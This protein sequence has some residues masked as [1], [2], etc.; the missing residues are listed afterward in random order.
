MKP[1]LLLIALSL[2]LPAAPALA[3]PKACNA[4]AKD[5]VLSIALPAAPAAAV[6]G[7]DGCTLYVSLPGEIA[8]LSRAD[9]AATLLHRSPVKGL[10]GALAVSPDGRMLAAATGEGATVLDTAR[11][12]SGQGDP[13]IGA[14]QEKGGGINVV[15]GKDSRSLFVAGG[16]SE[17]VGVFE[18]GKLA[19][20]GEIAVGRWSSGLALSPDGARLYATVQ[21]VDGKAADCSPPDGQASWMSPGELA[22]IDVAKAAVVGRAAAGCNPARVALSPSGDTAYVTARGD[23]A[24]TAIAA[25]TMSVQAPIKGVG[26]PVA[27][28]AGPGALFVTGSDASVAVLKPGAAPGSIAVKGG[29]VSAA[30]TADGRTLLVVETD[31]NTLDIVDLARAAK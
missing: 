24:V 15:F 25:K 4:P 19:R 21:F 10:G 17:A 3:Q 9:G 16:A 6:A 22:V 5:A 27:I 20:T 29:P 23:D 11:L 1:T 28:A 12:L 8:V 2:L 13:V 26:A 14:V 7:P 18:T 31:P 30:L